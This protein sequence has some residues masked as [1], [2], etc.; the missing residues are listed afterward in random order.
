MTRMW[1]RGRVNGVLGRRLKENKRSDP[2]R[3]IHC[4][5]GSYL[6]GDLLYLEAGPWSWY[7]RAWGRT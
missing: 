2:A 3:L 6:M 7:D 1:F 5:L 4:R